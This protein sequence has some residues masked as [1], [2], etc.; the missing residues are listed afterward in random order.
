MTL[1]ERQ[2]NLRHNTDIFHDQ[3]QSLLNKMPPVPSCPSA[4]S[5]RLANRLSALST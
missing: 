2:I 3:K 4:L 1:N 5:N